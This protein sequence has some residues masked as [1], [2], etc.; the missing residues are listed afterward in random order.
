MPTGPN[1]M[2]SSHMTNIQ[3]SNKAITKI[4]HVDLIIVEQIVRLKPIV[5]LKLLNGGEMGIH[6]HCQYHFDNHVISLLHV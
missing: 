5:A 6:Q 4:N 1:A 3:Y 2:V